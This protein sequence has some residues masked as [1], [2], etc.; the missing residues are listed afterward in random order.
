[1]G[2]PAPLVILAVLLLAAGALILL[3]AARRLAAVVRARF[4][5]G[6]PYAA[7]QITDRLL[8]LAMTLPVAPLGAALLW[9]AL[10]Q[11]AFQATRPDEAVRV[12]RLDASRSGWGRTAVRLSPDPL[13]PETRLLDGEIEGSRWAVTGEF[14]DWAP[15]VRWLGLRPAHRVR[16][17]IGT[18]DPS[19]TAPKQS[20]VAIDAAPSAARLLLRSARWI[21]F[22]TVRQGAS[23]WI[24]AGGRSVAVLYATSAGYLADTASTADTGR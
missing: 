16:A 6:A 24:A 23:P 12:G 22:L 10:A 20:T 17:L 11:G 19:G 9:L 5:F 14:L 18:G 4:T 2:P 1:M 21:P 7:G 3:R 8:G 13:Y 15:G